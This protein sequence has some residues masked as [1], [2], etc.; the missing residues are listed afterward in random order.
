M[1]T[2]LVF[3]ASKDTTSRHTGRER[4]AP[5][6]SQRSTAGKEGLRVTFHQAGRLSS[7]SAPWDTSP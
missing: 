1:C 6:S 4:M 2:V 7:H 5:H 3:S